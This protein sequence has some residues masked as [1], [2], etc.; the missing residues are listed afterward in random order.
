MADTIVDPNVVGVADDASEAESQATGVYKGKGNKK[1]F[2]PLTGK[3]EVRNGEFSLPLIKDEEHAKELVPSAEDRVFWMNAGRKM[4]ARI[5]MYSM[6]DDI[7][8]DEALNDAYTSFSLAYS[9]VVTDKTSEE[10][11]QKVRD[12]ILSEEKFEDLKV[13]L[14]SLEKAGG[15]KPVYVDYATETLNKPSGVRG[16]KAKE[17]AA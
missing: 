8:G 13:A 11:K 6:F 16:K 1:V 10:R 2:N 4:Q 3:D 5:Q 12:F 9:Q 15:L 17:V 14:E 7:F